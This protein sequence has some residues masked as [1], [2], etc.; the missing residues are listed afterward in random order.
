MKR[1]VNQRCAN[2]RCVKKHTKVLLLI[3]EDVY[4]SSDVNIQL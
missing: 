4:A 3:L 2:Q 1:C